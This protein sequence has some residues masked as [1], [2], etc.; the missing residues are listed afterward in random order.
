MTK[1]IYRVD[2]LSLDGSGTTVTHRFADTAYVSL[3]ALS[4]S[5][6][7][8]RT[9]IDG[10]LVQPGLIRR[11][12]Y[13]QGRTRGGIVIGSGTV[14]L[15]N[16]D[17]DFDYL[18]PYAF[19]GQ[20]FYIYEINRA[21]LAEGALQQ[22]FGVS[23]QPLMDLKTITFAVRDA[24]HALDV[25]LLTTRYAGTNAL[26]AGV[27][28]TASDLKGRVKP[29]AIGKLRN[30]TPFCVNTSRQIYQLDGVRGFVTGYTIATYDKRSALTKGADYTSQADMEANAPTAGQY[31]VWPAGGMYRTNAAHSLLTN[32]LTNA[33]A[34]G[35]TGCEVSSVLRYI[36]GASSFEARLE[37]DPD[38]GIYLADETTRL[39]ALN[40]VAPSVNAF[41]AYMNEFPTGSGGGGYFSSQLC[42]PLNLPYTSLLPAIAIGE[43]EIEKDS[44]QRVIPSEPER[45]LPIWRVNVRYGKNYRLMSETDLAGVALSELAIWSQ[46]YRTATA[47]D[48]SVLTQWPEAPELNVDSLLYDEADAQDEADRLLALHSVRRDMFKLSIPIDIIRRIPLVGGATPAKFGPHSRIHL[49]YPRFG[50]DSGKTFLVTGISQNTEKDTYELLIWG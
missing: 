39:N 38:C 5:G 27:E 6:V 43:S 37:N 14:E 8:A 15:S 9:F 34:F 32:D 48:A 17:G 24:N 25:N 16:P 11:D 35:T 2:L 40:L 33:T 22:F 41:L 46:E 44:L 21:T 12:L 47:S 36:S 49:T 29:S 4:P 18:L 45:G 28:G 7:P 13:G 30:I 3:P 26:P 10:N 31:R 42:D 1:P 20:L 19:D 50:L 23:E